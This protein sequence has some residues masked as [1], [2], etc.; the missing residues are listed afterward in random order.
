MANG[1]I[2]EFVDSADG[3]INRFT[4]LDAAGAPTLVAVAYVSG[5]NTFVVGEEEQVFIYPQNGSGASKEYVDGQDGLLQDQIDEKLSLGGVNLLAPGTWRVQQEDSITRGLSNYIVVQDDLLKLYHVQDPTSPEHGANKR[6]VDAAISGRTLPP[7]L[8]FKFTD[9]FN[10]Q[11]GEFYY[12]EVDG[13]IDL[14]LNNVSKDVVW[15]YNG[16]S[17]PVSYND[18]HIFTIYNVDSNGRWRIV[19]QGTIDSA[20][21]ESTYVA[22]STGDTHAN[23]SLSKSYDYYITIAGIC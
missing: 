3:T 7:G 4:I 19:R 9:T 15:N 23:G 5:D 21:W 17:E 12:G 1:D 16:L 20:R 8:R 18:E 11:E 22:F 10:V 6:Y 2:I 13:K 14:R